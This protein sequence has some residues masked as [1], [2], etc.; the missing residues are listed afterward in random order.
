LID[1]I[2]FAHYYQ[3]RWKVVLMIFCGCIALGTLYF[4][5]ATSVYRAQVTL[6]FHAS[7]QENEGLGST[8]GI[9]LALAGL[10]GE[11]S[12]PER[13]EG[14]GILKS[15]AFLLPFIEKMSLARALFPNRFDTKA[16]KSRR[17]PTGEEL[18]RAFL[19]RAMVIDDNFATGLITISIF[20][21]NAAEAAAVANTLTA[22]LNEKLRLNAV[23]RANQDIA[24]LEKQLDSNPVA[25]IRV[26]IAQLI[27][28]E[29]RR[30]LLA[31]GQTT[32]TFQVIDPAF[33]PDR[34]Y[35]PRPVLI[36]AVSLLSAFLLSV[37]FVLTS[38]LL[39]AREP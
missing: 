31:N 4:F 25:E 16:L 22:D 35:A 7:S 36:A 29:M 23:A 6:Q 10:Q 1:L 21:P 8:L 32:Q 26:S 13:A 24:Y 19:G 3:R 39:H 28:T 9:G 20:M 12:I 5:R 11:K 37:F 14:I 27:Q 15:R 17:P 38:Y 30:L 2:Q 34:I 33:A 18:H